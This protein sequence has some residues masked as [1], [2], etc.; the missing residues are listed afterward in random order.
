[1]YF[2]QMESKTADS[3]IHISSSTM[4]LFNNFLHNPCLPCTGFVAFWYQP[5]RQQSPTDKSVLWRCI[6]TTIYTVSNIT[7]P[8]YNGVVIKIL[9]KHAVAKNITENLIR[10]SR[11]HER[12]RRQTDDR[13]QTTDRRI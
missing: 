1:M 2:N 12:C 10:L 8:K 6:A 4:V 3:R 9:G 13:R 11:V 5:C 7:S